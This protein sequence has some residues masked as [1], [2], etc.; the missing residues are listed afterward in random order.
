MTNSTTPSLHTDRYELTMLDAALRDGIADRDAV[1]EVF[2]RSLPGNHRFGVIAGINRV[3]DAVM[4][5]TFDPDQVAWLHSQGV[6][7]D[8]AAE[9]LTAYAFSGN[10]IGYAEGDVYLAY[11][12]VLRVEGTFAECVIL[13]TLVLSILNHDTA[14]ASTAV[15]MVTA[16]KGKTLIE[17]GS[18]RTHEE[19]A[20]HAARAAYIAGFTGTS[21]LEA[22]YRDD[23]PTL[24]TAA[25]ASIL[26]HRVEA[27]AFVGQIAAQGLGTTLLVDTYDI[28]AGI[29]KAVQ[30][31]RQF[32]GDGPGAVRIDSGDLFEEAVKARAQLDSY[33]CKDTK[34]VVSGDLD[35]ARIDAL[36]QQGAPIDSFGVGTRLVTGANCP[37]PGF[38]YKLVAIEAEDGS[39]RPVAKKSASK[40]TSGGTTYAYRVTEDF[41]S[42]VF[43]VSQITE[44]FVLGYLEDGTGVVEVHTKRPVGEDFDGD[45]Y[46]LQMHFVC[47]GIDVRAEAFPLIAA[48]NRCAVNLTELQANHLDLDGEVPVKAVR[49]AAEA[50]LV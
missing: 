23:I 7:S 25:H 2:G 12:P 11:S 19:S 48:R 21:N 31:A 26:A 16:A 15:R 43:G 13:E 33:G 45:G 44:A 36:V 4:D 42:D 47:Q 27:E 14:V 50:T 5:F 24:G 41:L 29:E 20:V 37:S 28:E 3:I 6:V 46:N 1:F 38:V 18:R 32:G 39:M 17:M 49:L 22:G 9:Y 35:E 40:A 10:I 34:I 8:T 30:T